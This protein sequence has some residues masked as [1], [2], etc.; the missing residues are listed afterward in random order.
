MRWYAVPNQSS[1][2]DTK[3]TRTRPAIVV[4]EYGEQVAEFEQLHHA[5]AV[6]DRHNRDTK[7]LA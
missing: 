1:R 5:E 7:E 2:S 6:V 3:S 4:D